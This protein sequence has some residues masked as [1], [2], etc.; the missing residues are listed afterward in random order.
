MQS[1]AHS[2]ITFI[3]A[4]YLDSF[5]GTEKIFWITDKQIRTFKINYHVNH[6]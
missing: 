6:F 2:Q 3:F 5:Q 4:Q 1:I